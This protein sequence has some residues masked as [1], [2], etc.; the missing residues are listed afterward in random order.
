MR[1]YNEE[2]EKL[3]KIYFK[4]YEVLKAYIFGIIIALAIALI[5]Y[6]PITNV[7]YLTHYFKLFLF[8]GLLNTLL[9]VYLMLY[10]KDKVL[11]SYNEEVKTVNLLYIRL[12]DLL[13]VTLFVIVLYFILIFIF[14]W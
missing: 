2:S 13:I 14:R 4:P 5:I 6:L 8:I 1:K 12:I 3:K 7:M 11:E 9:F 10:F